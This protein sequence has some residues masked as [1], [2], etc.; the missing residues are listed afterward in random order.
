M[1]GGL[2]FFI[3]PCLLGLSFFV[4][5]KILKRDAWGMVLGYLTLLAL[6]VIFRSAWF[7][8][9]IWLGTFL[10]L[11]YKWRGRTVLGTKDEGRTTEN[12]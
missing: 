2:T 11:V 8:Y 4:W 9:P 1:W 7:Y 6:F 3:I 10:V 12:S 5:I